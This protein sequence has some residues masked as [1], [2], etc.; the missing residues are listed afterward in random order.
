METGSCLAG[1]A[2]PRVIRG[3]CR[4]SRAFMCMC[5]CVCTRAHPCVCVNSL[6]SVCETPCPRA[7]SCFISEFMGPISALLQH[8]LKR[9]RYIYQQVFHSA[10]CHGSLRCLSCC[11][12]GKS[13]DPYPTKQ[14]MLP[15]WP[16]VK[17]IKLTL[18]GLRS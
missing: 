1:T 14:S 10:L 5:A 7:V 15:V 8:I 2:A 18:N 13:H 17:M 16:T 11:Y 6:T 4:D 3:G 12:S 9:K